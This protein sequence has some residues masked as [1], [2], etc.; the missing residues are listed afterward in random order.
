MDYPHQSIDNISTNAKEMQFCA[1]N[2][3]G[4]HSKIDT[5]YFDL[6]CS[7]YD[8]LCFSERKAC[9]FN[10]SQILLHDYTVFSSKDQKTS[11]LQLMVCAF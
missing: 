10:F 9:N 3:C 6:F 4:L 7:I 8:I 5:D 1:L 11:C 2:V